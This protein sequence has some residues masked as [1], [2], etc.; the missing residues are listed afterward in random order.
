MQQISDE[1][2]KAF[3][4]WYAGHH[5]DAAP[6]SVVQ[7]AMCGHLHTYTKA[8]AAMLRRCVRLHLVRVE[9]DVVTFIQKEKCN[10]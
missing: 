8:A 9:A 2:L 10:E 6:V 5:Q 4:K 1:Q 7:T 3:C